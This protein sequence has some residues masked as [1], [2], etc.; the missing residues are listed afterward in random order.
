MNELLSGKSNGEM[1]FSGV[2]IYKINYED[3][4]FEILFEQRTEA[5]ISHCGGDKQHCKWYKPHHIP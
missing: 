3:L 1:N 5:W 2:S 4:Q